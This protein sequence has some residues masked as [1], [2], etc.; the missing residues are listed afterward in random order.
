MRLLVVGAGGHAKVV[1]DT[2][3][4]AGWEIAGI[5]GLATDVPDVLG[6][7]V[8]TDDD[9]IEADAFIIAIGD[10]A[11]R[12]RYFAEYRAKGLPG[13]RVIHPSAIVSP[14]ATIAEGALVVGG[15]VVNALARIGENAILNTSCA[16]DHDVVVGDHV[17][18]GPASCLCGAVRLDEGVTFGAGATAAPL[19]HVGAWSVCGAGAAVV[20]DLPARMVCV[21]VPAKPVHP[22]GA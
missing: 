15:V 22:V 19:T 6:F 8:T 16:V 12:A 2:A 4:A 11:T 20:T 10:N 3:L 7:P 1:V 17:L 14:S 13:A 18:V 5:V 21:G 9:G